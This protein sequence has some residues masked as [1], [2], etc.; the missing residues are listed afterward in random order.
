M[1]HN[2]FVAGCARHPEAFGI[3][4]DLVDT[5]TGSKVSTTLARLEDKHPLV[6]TSLLP[7]FYPAGFRP[8]AHQKKF[9]K[10]ANQLR[11]SITSAI[12]VDLVDEASILSESHPN[13]LEPV[14][15]VT[16]RTFESR[17]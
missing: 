11:H 3:N 8:P 6:G 15:T 14:H 13:I 12:S 2:L 5:I 1:L 4:T 9:W 7:I 16:G 17:I 10:A